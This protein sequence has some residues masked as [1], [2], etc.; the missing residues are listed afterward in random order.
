MK[1]GLQKV[2]TPGV[3]SMISLL[4]A[5]LLANLSLAQTVKN[6]SPFFEPVRVIQLID[7]NNRNRQYISSLSTLLNEIQLRT[8]A[9]LDVEPLLVSTLTDSALGEHS[10]LYINV[11]GFD[12]WEMTPE[13]TLALKQFIESGGFV[14]L[15]AG[16]KSE[17]LRENNRG[18]HSFAD[19]EIRPSV[20]KL[21]RQMFPEH[22]FTP[23]PRNHAVF[24]LVYSGLPDAGELPEAIRDFVVNEKWP[25]GTYSLLGMELNGRLAVIASP[26]IAMGWGKN[27]TG[28]WL[29]Q[30]DFRVREGSDQLSQ[31]LSLAAYSGDK[32]NANRADGLVDIIFTQKNERPGWVQE[33][34]GDYRAFRY[35][36]GEEISDFAHLFYTRLGINIFVYGMLN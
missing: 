31:R 27:E 26:I 12:K 22:N 14:Y 8:T 30:I 7:A 11:D 4:T 17:F 23:I 2:K 20:G 35:Y 10:L 28:N 25:G 9:S 18:I 6:N 36:S 34:G 3:A 29:Y 21:F 24:H 1:K 5:L 32:F 19:W 16:I 13:E 15:D 33:P